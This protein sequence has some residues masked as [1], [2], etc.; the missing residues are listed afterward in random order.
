MDKEQAKL[1]LSCARPHGADDADPAVRE[2]LDF[3]QS[4]A[5]LRA[6]LEAERAM[7]RELIRKI[8]SVPVPASLRQEI[9][10]AMR[11]E[12]V[13][14]MWQRPQVWA[15]A[16]CLLVLVGLVLP[17]N[18][19]K[20]TLPAAGYADMRQDI[21]TLVSSGSFVPSHELEGLAKAQ[22]WLGQKKAPPMD[23]LPPFLADAQT[24][25]CTVM[26][27]RGRTV[28]GLC[29]EK[30][31][32]LMHVFV[33]D[34]EQLDALPPDGEVLR[35]SFGGH[36]TLAWNSPKHFFVLVGDQSTT[37]LELLIRGS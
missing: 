9:L 6:W 16:A 32:K 18:S 25:A 33:V 8:K 23:D 28:G 1:I 2:A 20:P 19:F 11:R 29:L 5:E 27:W 36:Q 10:T 14:P 34:R 37:D 26:E 35:A 24:V 12:K 7:D 3:V 13:V 30:N 4:D 21:G 31:G 15:L 17:E 22:I